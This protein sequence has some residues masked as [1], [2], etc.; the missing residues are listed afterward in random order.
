MEVNGESGSLPLE[1][2]DRPGLLASGDRNERDKR[3]DPST[4]SGD[5]YQS[6]T[7]KESKRLGESG[8]VLTALAR[9]GI[10]RNMNLCT[11]PS[12]SRCR[13]VDMN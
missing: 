11:T 10:N 1:R 2:V 5:C 9:L 13:V 8:S 7:T 12:S 6:V 3:K 4:W